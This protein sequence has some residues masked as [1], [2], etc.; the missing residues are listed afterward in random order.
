MLMM[1]PYTHS[2]N[3]TAFGNVTYQ[4]KESRMLEIV[5]S[6]QNT[7][8]NKYCGFV[9]IFYQD[10]LLIP[11]IQK[12]NMKHEEKL[13][14]VPSMVDTISTLF[15]YAN[16][17]LQRRT[18]IL[19]TSEIPIS[20]S[21]IAATEYILLPL[22][23]VFKLTSI[24]FLYS[25]NLWAPSIEFCL[26]FLLHCLLEKCDVTNVKMLLPWVWRWH[27]LPFLKPYFYL[28][29]KFHWV[30]G[31]IFIQSKRALQGEILQARNQKFLCCGYDSFLKE[32]VPHTLNKGVCFQNDSPSHGCAWYR[33][34]D[35]LG[36]STSGIQNHEP[37]LHTENLSQP[38]WS[39]HVRTQGIQGQLEAF[40]QS[41]S[42][43]PLVLKQKKVQKINQKK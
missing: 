25:S 14:F 40:L 32:M 16:E 38:L 11:Y 8:N 41:V 20:V 12:Q 31:C 30:N 33:E 6:I 42:N 4:Q 24:F 3:I 15:R 36:F 23:F 37:L 28:S 35:L 26:F 1:V 34:C 21:G 39:T 9:Y 10:P 43:R 13:V 7:L 19:Q 5:D 27:L 18:V 29:Q 2:K 22:I 17:K